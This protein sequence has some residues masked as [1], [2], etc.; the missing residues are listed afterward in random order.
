[1]RANELTDRAYRTDVDDGLIAV[2]S[3]HIKYLN[4]FAAFVNE[5]Q[6]WAWEV[7]HCRILGF[8]WTSL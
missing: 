2:G 7:H 8:N 1:M 6:A 3:D 4:H 5:L